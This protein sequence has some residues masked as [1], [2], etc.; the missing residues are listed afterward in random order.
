MSHWKARR[1]A[2]RAVKVLDRHKAQSAAIAAYE[3]SLRTA[4][5]DFIRIYAQATGYESTW[6][7]E[8]TEGRGAMAEL[9]RT[10][11]SWKPHVARERPGF[12]LTTIADRPT[13]P[14]DLIEDALALADE[15]DRIV[16]A[17]GTTREW[18]AGGAAALRAAAQK[19][20][21]ETDE[22]AAAD[23]SYN[24]LL[25]DTRGAYTTFNAELSRFRATL[26]SVLGSSH[27]DFQKLR[28]ER[29]GTADT[30]D[31]PGGPVPSDPVTPAPTPPVL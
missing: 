22:S 28:A 6:R 15:H 13:V 26:R 23:A 11:E 16:D 9:K 31:D 25:A 2:S 7:V 30:D 20:E 5:G 3:Q 4:A 29:S 1:L 24:K 8:M 27:P 10:I 12:D 14:E 19:A 21:K 17:S 18:A